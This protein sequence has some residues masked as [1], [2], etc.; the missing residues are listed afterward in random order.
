M[1]GDSKHRI[2]TVLSGVRGILF[3]VDGVVSIGRTP[4][5]G[6]AEALKHLSSNGIPY[7]FVT[8]TTTLSRM[9]LYERLRAMGLPLEPDHL[10]TTH[11]VAARYLVDR[12]RPTCLLLVAD[13][14]REAYQGIPTDESAPDI[15]LV[16]D[17]GD[18]WDYALLNR[19]FNMIM[20]GAEIVALH[21]GRYWQ[22]EEGL[23]MDIGAFVAALEYATGKSATIL[24]KPEAAFFEIA[25]A[26]L[27]LARDDVVMIGDD[28]ES[29]VG[30]A[31][32]AGIRGILV[33]T[34]KYNEDAVKRS[35]VEPYAVISSIA[36]LVHLI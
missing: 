18:R 19:V 17:I 34:G 13:G 7:R 29:D 28:I 2:V 9:N 15:V 1:P 6:A 35:S 16:G 20:S 3:D 32:R 30:G 31:Q 5:P 21:K 36:E 33:K 23:N 25:L 14:V 24:G 11:E 12:G 26:D 4:I 10:F 8:N 27:G 22:T